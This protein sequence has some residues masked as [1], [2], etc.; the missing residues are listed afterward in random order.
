MAFSARGAG[1]ALACGIVAIAGSAR[2]E[3][4]ASD[5]ETARSLMVQG[6]AQRDKNDLKGALQSFLAADAIMHVPT[7]GLEVARSENALAMLVEARDMAIQVAHIPTTRRESPA[8]ADARAK[9]LSLSETLGERIPSL[10]IALR[11]APDGATPEVTIDGAPVPPNALSAPRKLNPGRHQVVAKAGTYQGKQDVELRERDAKT[12]VVEMTASSPEHAEAPSDAPA[13][14]PADEPKDTP[15][16]PKTSRSYAL[17]YAAFG[18]GGLGVLVGSVT[19]VMSLT[20]SSSLS[21]QCPDNKCPE[22]DTPSFQ[23]QL[24]TAKTLGTVSTVSFVVG[25]AG[26]LTGVLSIVLAPKEPPPRMSTAH[27]T[28]WISPRGAGLT[29]TF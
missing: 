2:A 6:Q 23:D 27:V 28:P 15:P 4:S 14:A 10:V 11:A 19:G 21:D 13:A 5:K 18:V 29:G 16:P 12:V 25:G 1:A 26:I 20:K 7:T 9:A 22:Y 17:T 3:P 24:G 8:F